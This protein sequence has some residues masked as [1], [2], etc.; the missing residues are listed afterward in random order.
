MPLRDIQLP[1]D[2]QPL[3]EMIIQTFQYPENPDWSVQEE[4]GEF[5]LD[6][7]NNLSRIWWLLKLA[8]YFSEVVRDIFC[9]CIWEE[10]GKIVGTTIVQRRG[11]TKVWIVGTVGVLPEYRR[12]GIARA[13]VERGLEI[14][15][16]KG[17]EKAWLDV[18]EGN[19]PARKLYQTLGFKAYSGHMELQL[20]PERVFEPLEIPQ[21]YTQEPLSLYDWKPRFELE[22][23]ISPEALLKYEPVEKKRFQH[24]PIM[25]IIIPLIHFAQGISSKGYLVRDSKGKI[26]ARHAYS[27]M[28]RDKGINEIFV[29][30]DSEH[31]T[32][33]PY[34]V[35]FL[36]NQ[37]TTL[38][39]NLKV[40]FSV[41][42]WMETVLNAGR[43]AG[44]DT[45]MTMHRMGIIL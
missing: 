37:V 28:R 16:E 23:R 35:S 30:I 38:K 31:E 1:A 43:N 26:V 29:R 2:L 40:Q 25:R 3:S 11:G 21:G 15:R 45:R 42:L 19:L 8:G 4:E 27:I 24:P 36:L 17:G 5:L 44:F 32:L 18:I 41:P 10:E 12:R 9:G 22:N 13:L 20:L 14:I 7:I 6:S 39:P 34:S 33:A